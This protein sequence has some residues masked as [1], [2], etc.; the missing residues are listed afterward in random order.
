MYEVFGFLYIVFFCSKKKTAYDMR[1]SVWSSDVCSSDLRTVFWSP[2]AP[3]TSATI[4]AITG[5]WRNARAGT[6]TCIGNTGTNST[7]SPDA[8]A[9]EPAAISADRKSVVKGKSVSVR[10]DHGVR[11]I[12]QQ[13]QT[14]SHVSYKSR[15]PNKN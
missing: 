1:I 7:C 2:T 5:T 6:T 13:K 8:I 15:K 14:E 9:A 10:V 4:T 12:I 11:R 3:D